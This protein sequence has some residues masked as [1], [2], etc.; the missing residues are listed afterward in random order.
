MNFKNQQKSLGVINNEIMSKNRKWKQVNMSKNDSNYNWNYN[1]C[2][3]EGS[4]ERS[5]VFLRKIPRNL[6]IG[7]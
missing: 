7:D 4:D 2:P 6:F 5:E 1:I 3:I